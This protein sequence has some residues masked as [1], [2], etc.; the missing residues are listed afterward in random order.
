MKETT[1]FN[2][3]YEEKDIINNFKIISYIQKNDK[4]LNLKNLLNIVKFLVINVKT[5]KDKTT[6]FLI[7][8][9]LSEKGTNNIIL[10]NEETRKIWSTKDEDIEKQSLEKLLFGNSYYEFIQSKFVIP[11]K[12]ACDDLEVSITFPKYINE[13]AS[14]IKITNNNNKDFPNSET[15]NNENLMWEFNNS[16]ERTYS[17]NNDFMN[18]YSIIKDNNPDNYPKSYIEI[19]KYI[20]KNWNEH[21]ILKNIYK[22]LEDNT[23]VSTITTKT[24]GIYLIKETRDKKI[25]AMIRIISKETKELIQKQYSIYTSII[26][27]SIF[28]YFNNYNK[29]F[30]ISEE[31]LKLLFILTFKFHS[32]FNKNKD[33]TETNNE[34]INRIIEI[35]KK[36][37]NNLY[38]LNKFNLNREYNFQ[39]ENGII[40]IKIK[41]EI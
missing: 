24:L 19:F 6:Y 28:N 8:E 2:T 14:K 21:K 30:N 1:I 7:N 37:S 31:D 9:K 35:A 17:I 33:Q 34:F 32:Y 23:T 13:I 25:E 39:R 12:F 36:T 10:F 15:I 27:K 18:Y 16:I 22:D 26:L 11:L 41:E 4:I 29:N 20:Y 38:N 40:Q 5:Q 3:K